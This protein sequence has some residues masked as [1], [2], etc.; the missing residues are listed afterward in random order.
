MV[1]LSLDIFARRLFTSLA[2]LFRSLFCGVIKDIVMLMV[3][4]FGETARSLIG[5]TL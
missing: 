1:C 4:V 2:L 3:L 5:L